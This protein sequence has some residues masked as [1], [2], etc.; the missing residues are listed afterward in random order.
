MAGRRWQV[1][2]N[3][4]NNRDFNNVV[5][6]NRGRRLPQQR[7]R[8]GSRR[9]ARSLVDNWEIV[10]IEMDEPSAVFTNRL[11]VVFN[12]S[13][14]VPS[15]PQHDPPPGVARRD[16]DPYREFDPIMDSLFPIPEHP[17]P[18]ETPQQR[19]ARLARN[20]TV[21]PDYALRPWFEELQPA[22][23]RVYFIHPNGEIQV[24]ADG[25]P[26]QF[27]GATFTNDF[28]GM[29]A[30]R[31]SFAKTLAEFVDQYQ[32]EDIA[33]GDLQY[34]RM[35]IDISPR[36]GGA[37]L[38][39]TLPQEFPVGVVWTPQGYGNCAFK[40]F[41]QAVR[42]DNRGIR[43]HQ[44]KQ[45][46][47]ME[48]NCSYVD[49]FQEFVD[50]Y[51]KFSVRLLSATGYLRYRKDGEQFEYEPDTVRNPGGLS[52][53]P[54][55]IYLLLEEKHYYLVQLVYQFI[56]TVR[57]NPEA[58]YCHG[59][60][61]MFR[62]TPEWQ[63]HECT[64]DKVCDRCQMFFNVP[65]QQENHKKNN[66]L[67]LERI[68]CDYCGQSNF[69]SEEC[70]VH[71]EL[72][73]PA[74]QVAG[75]VAGVRARNE[76]NPTCPACAERTNGPGHICYM[77]PA[78][79]PDSDK[80]DE[81]YA[82]DFECL[83]I[84]HHNN[85]YLHQINKVCVQQIGNPEA[86]WDFDTAEEFI[87]WI[88][89]HCFERADLNFALFAHNLKGYDGRLML[90]EIYKAQRVNDAAH[91][92]DMIWTGAKINTFKWRNVAF[93]DSLLHI[94]AQLAQFPKIF[95]LEALQKGHFPYMFNTLENQNYIGPIP[96]I[97]Y[98]E[99]EYKS[100]KERK[101]LLQ[102]YGEQV[103]AGQPYNF[104][105]VL[106]DYCLSDV[107][108]LARAL[109]KYNDAGRVL[110]HNQLP[111]LDRL[112]IASYTLNCWR[113]LHF[114]ENTIVNHAKWE[115]QRARAA[116][117]GGRT[118]VRCFYRRWSMEDVFVH[119]R[120]GKYVDVQSMY[121]YV[122]YTQPMPV[123][124][125]E[126]FEEDRATLELI[127]DDDH[128]L[129]F[130]EVDID[131]PMFYT[132]HPAAVHV[133]ESGRLVGHL[134]PW[135]RKTFCLTELRDMLN[136]G[137]IITHIYWI[138]RYQGRDDLFKDYISKLVREK[139]HASSGPPEN[140]EEMSAAWAEKF[141]VHLKRDKMVFNAG[142]RQIAK[143]QLNSLWGKLAERCKYDFC[144]N[145]DQEEFLH[146][147]NMELSGHIQFKH[148]LRIG[149]NSWLLAGTK[150]SIPSYT[151]AETKN[152]C[153]TS[154]AIG[155]HVTM[156]GR[157]MLW[158]EMR[159]LQK[160]AIYHDTDSIIYEYDPAAAYN[161]PTGKYLGDWEE[162]L[163]GC[164]MIEFVALAPKTY[165]Y[166]YIDL[167]KGIPIPKDAPLDWF[168]QYPHYEVWQDKLY[169]VEE[170]IK[171][172]GIRL[173]Y[174]ALQQINF[175]GLLDL[176]LGRQQTLQAT[177]LQF[178]Y[179][180]DLNQ[181]TTRHFQKDLIFQYEKGL[182]GLNVILTPIPLGRT[183]TGSTALWKK[184]IVFAVG[185]VPRI[186]PP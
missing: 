77:K 149:P 12:T 143:L 99:P 40:C 172:K 125:P 44:L 62:S 114:P 2:F 177:Q 96:D 54:Y 9:S 63:N 180:R 116:L 95:G 78:E 184:V 115:E 68:A 19:R 64:D 163:P 147:E 119:H 67:E 183:T 48:D 53:Q 39:K 94:P 35:Y 80:F 56:R 144:Y 89:E 23:L 13:F 76:R 51:P 97:Q 55:C 100:V 17:R 153:N 45:N 117:R 91:V 46:L 132:H 162:E 167:S 16:W 11:E 175:D 127:T 43:W 106:T 166:R 182:R 165:A 128:L 82:F 111:P 170:K 98:F 33:N 60:C 93:R 57:E 129:G 137:W 22:R 142:Q 107:D 130:A 74:R 90:C 174:S 20:S 169:V 92:S 124:K 79:L 42:F 181:I 10:E 36:I 31:A 156:W 83:L 112:T 176:F 49:L 151:S 179:D 140:F 71:H 185:A 69:Y 24:L 52:R 81:M 145:V 141:D 5:G 164:A 85:S 122:M 178:K 14:I 105:Q 134:K 136:D 47:G 168:R 30:L 103:A 160:R 126:T 108:I 28:Q 154:V 139:I 37:A 6:G 41:A 26:R 148:K 73:C 38:P 152:R 159:K 1:P 18:N 104:K 58:Q 8:R 121:P 131:P 161:T 34:V 155:S 4:L 88:T 186:M 123:G 61:L 32:D 173:H 118:D 158:Q 15:A 157:R 110:N 29:E 135:F 25:S 3:N 101:E 50:K 87:Q 72:L 65:W 84:P 21:L 75:R 138:Q 66:L 113:T 59:C 150:T 109:E 133:D 171:V 70:Q 102:W 27:G 86:V 7:Q 120:Y 146:F